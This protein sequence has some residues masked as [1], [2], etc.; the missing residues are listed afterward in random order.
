[1]QHK[2][3]T[4]GRTCQDN[5]MSHALLQWPKIAQLIESQGRSCKGSF[6]EEGKKETGELYNTSPSG[7]RG[8]CQ[9]V[10]VGFKGVW[11]SVFEDCPEHCEPQCELVHTMSGAAGLQGSS[12]EGP[13]TIFCILGHLYLSPLPS[14]AA[15]C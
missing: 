9:R 12:G 2:I 11:K 13:N 14:I 6:G 4:A 3:L 7:K 10:A 5:S 15:V 1:M 8:S